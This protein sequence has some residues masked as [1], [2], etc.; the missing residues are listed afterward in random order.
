[1]KIAA[2]IAT[3]YA[4]LIALIVAVLAYQLSLF[5][6][7]QSVNQNLSDIDFRAGI[8]SLQMLRDLDQVEEFTRKF[9]ATGGDPDYASQIDEMGDAVTQEL[10]ELESLRVS[11][12]EKEAVD[13]LSG[14]WIELSR[15]SSAQGKEFRS[16][17]L[18]ELET[19]LSDQLALFSSLRIQDQALIR[20]TRLAIE[21]RVEESSQAG[22][23]A[24]RIAWIAAAAALALSLLVSFWI[25]RS[26]SGPL[27]YL[28]E[29]TRA[30]AEGKFFYQLDSSG[31]DELAQLAGDF[32]IMTRRLSELDELKKDFVAHVSHEL[33]TPLASMQETVR[34]LLDEIPGAL[35]EQQKRFLEFNLRS[36]R[37]LSAL[38]GNLL[39][40]SRIEAGVMQYDIQKHDLGAL[41]RT[42]LEE[43]EAPLREKS[44]HLEAQLPDEPFTVE[45]DETRII[46]VVGNL[47]GNALKFSPRGGALR[48]C[49]SHEAK[50]PDRVPA[51]WRDRLSGAR[52]GAGFALLSIADSGPGIPAAEKGKIFEK[53]HQIRQENKIPGQGAGL[54]LAIGRTIVEAHWGAIWVEDNSGGG[55]VFCVLLGAGAVAKPALIRSSS[56][57]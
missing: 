52:D 4:T 38:I 7:M 48:V 39:D 35:N 56:P 46:Q 42:V 13:R 16:M 11:A 49:L 37:R 44:L 32:N 50:L 8:L 53:F 23:R 14:L 41:I 6:R 21:S 43:F 40:L 55:S 36:S 25:I 24:Q 17:K 47:M 5:S 18:P 9:F 29:G 34:L 20:A 27:H 28:T 2:K 54:G 33:K 22:K 30:V 45:C 15:T 1:M 31:G 10:R 57:I 26:I 51:G 19:A 12:A 3:G